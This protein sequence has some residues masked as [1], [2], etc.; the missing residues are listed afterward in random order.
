MLVADIDGRFTTPNGRV[1]WATLR[2][3]TAWGEYTKDALRSAYRISKRLVTP[4]DREPQAVAA[5]HEHEATSSTS[6]GTSGSTSSASASSD[7]RTS[8]KRK[9]SWS[10]RQKDGY[11]AEEDAF[12]RQ[13]VERDGAKRATWKAIVDQRDWGDKPPTTKAIKVY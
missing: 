7:L 6:S 13:M 12:I 9:C 8:R 11:T 4:V 2:Q 5:A 3:Q 1:H 10:M